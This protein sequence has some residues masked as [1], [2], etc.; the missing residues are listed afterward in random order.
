MAKRI[1]GG[2]AMPTMAQ[3]EA[4]RRRINRHRIYVRIMQST[5]GVLVVVAALAALISSLLLPV[6][7][8]SGSSMEPT[9]REGEI[10]VLVKTGRLQT[11]DLCSFTWNNRTLVKRII[12]GPGA[13]VEI[14]D[15]GTVYVDKVAL[16]EPYVTGKA[17]G[18]CDIEFPY[19]VPA[20]HYFVMGDHRD[21]SIDSRSTVVGSVNK[22]QIIGKVV[23]RVWPWIHIGSIN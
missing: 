23:F 18:E 11:G 10:V 5:L 14:D 13:W 17:L 21:T 8:I 3:V 6:M 22:D 15:Q 20:D 9:L 12:A 4:E 2:A 16:D 7:Q 19:Q 1:W